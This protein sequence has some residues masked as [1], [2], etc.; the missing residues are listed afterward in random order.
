MVTPAVDSARKP[1][2]DGVKRLTQMVDDLNAMFI[3]TQ[4][5]TMELSKP[6]LAGLGDDI[7]SGVSGAGAAAL[8]A[9]A[10][11]GPSTAPRQGGAAA[12]QSDGAVGDGPPRL[13][14]LSD[15]VA[16][17]LTTVA[18]QA[19]L[20]TGVLQQLDRCVMQRPLWV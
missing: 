10:A 18:T 15:Q 4:K 13:Q 1:T 16:G 8:G 2:E 19:P 14:L 3:K 12:V 11:G 7:V 5:D 20:T 9:T 6:P 17:L